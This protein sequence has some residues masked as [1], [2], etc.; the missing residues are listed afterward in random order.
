MTK[1]LLFCFI[2]LDNDFKLYWVKYN[3]FLI[4]PTLTNYIFP[5]FITLFAWNHEEAH[6][7]PGQIINYHILHEL[8]A[9]FGAF[10]RCV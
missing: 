8:Y 9:K 7:G 2:D 1:N 3:R 6:L 5:N 10:V 4:L